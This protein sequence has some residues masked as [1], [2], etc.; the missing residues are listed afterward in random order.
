MVLRFVL[1]LL[2]LVTLLA[3]LCVYVHRRLA[4]LLGLQRAGRRALAAVLAGGRVAMLVGRAAGRLDEAAGSWA[5]PLAIAGS[6]LM[7]AVLV[8]GVLF[9]LVDAGAGLTR[10]GARLRRRLPTRK[11]DAP[12]G[13]GSHSKHANSVSEPGAPN[14]AERSATLGR[15][16]LV[17]RG[18]LAAAA[19]TGAGSSLYGAL[20]GRHDYRVETVPVPLPGLDRRLDGYTIVQLSDLHF[21]TFAGE[22]ELAIAV[23][24]VRAA[25]PDLVVLT[26][27]LVDH[28]PRHAVLVGRLTARLVELARDGVAAV[29]GN[30][31]YYAGVGAI[32]DALERAGARTLVNAAARLGDADHGFVLAGVDDPWMGEA[33]LERALAGQPSDAPVLLLCHN[34]V[35]FPRA[36]PRVGLQ[37]SG[38]THGGQVNIGP[39]LADWVLPYGYV[40]GLYERDGS[41]LY[42]NRGFGVAGP[43]ARVGAPPEVTRIVLTS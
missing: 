21:G 43:P 41:R 42:V 6:T 34:P 29:P 27:D 31:D 39:R 40:A 30:H 19:A 11:P 37:L 36:A 35:Y 32:L 10:L 8:S 16:E 4:W 17:V 23:D 18:A 9:L 13:E 38:H 20:V 1:F 33:D 24:L 15:R 12:E 14:S 7:L 5:A 2:V 26:G 22:R 3:A 28:D 25:R